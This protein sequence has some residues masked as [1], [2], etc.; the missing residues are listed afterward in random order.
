MN[1]DR[2]LARV[3]IH[4]GLRLKPY[5]DTVGKLT[6]G[7]GRNLDDV[8]I[9]E[10]EAAAML[11]ADLLR[12]EKDAKSLVPSFP[13]LSSLR[14]EVLVEMVFNLGRPRLAG[15]K[16]FLAAVESQNWNQAHYEMLESKWAVQVGHRAET[17]ARIMRDNSET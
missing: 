12:A 17:L 10:S 14:Q 8:G 2:L 15:F 9:S 13:L 16:K 3:C 4:E 5:T 11:D 6:I 7:Y 1:L